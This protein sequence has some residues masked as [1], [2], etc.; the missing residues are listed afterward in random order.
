MTIVYIKDS[1]EI[2]HP[3]LVDISHQA[4]KFINTTKIL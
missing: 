3:T 4:S 2:S 1:T